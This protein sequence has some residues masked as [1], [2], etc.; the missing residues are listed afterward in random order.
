[1]ERS[2]RSSLLDLDRADPLEGPEDGNGD[3]LGGIH[4]RAIDRQADLGEQRVAEEVVGWC[5]GGLHLDRVTGGR[6]HS[7]LGAAACGD[8]D[9][10]HCSPDGR[11]RSDGRQHVP[12]HASLAPW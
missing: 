10:G 12:L 4:P 8:D 7:R 6:G 3:H 1:M 11:E 2:P 5:D 9:E